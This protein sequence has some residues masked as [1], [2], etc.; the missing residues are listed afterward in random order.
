MTEIYHHSFKI[1]DFNPKSIKSRKIGKK[2]FIFKKSIFLF[3]N[4]RRYAMKHVGNIE[5]LS[6]KCMFGGPTLAHSENRKM[7]Q[8]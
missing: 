2:V 4:L 1:E 8:S 5:S 3:N 6:D 7:D